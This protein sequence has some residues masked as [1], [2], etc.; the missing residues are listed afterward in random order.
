MDTFGVVGAAADASAGMH[1]S[2]RL[3]IRFCAGTWRLSEDGA[4][5]IGGMF[6][7]L[8][9]AVDYALG[10]LRGVRGGRV[11]LELDGR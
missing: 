9:S 2:R 4:S 6:S 3:I 5:W 1:S 8:S 11:V 10:E 7:S